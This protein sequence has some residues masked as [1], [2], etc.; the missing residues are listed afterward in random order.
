MVEIL[1]DEADEDSDEDLAVDSVEMLDEIEDDS[2]LEKDH[3]EEEIMIAKQV[4][5]VLLITTLEEMLDEKQNDTINQQVIDLEVSIIG[6]DSD[7]EKDDE[8]DL[9][10]GEALPIDQPLEP[11]DEKD[12]QV[13]TT[14]V[15]ENQDEVSDEEVDNTNKVSK[16]HKHNQI[17]QNYSYNGSFFYSNSTPLKIDILL[18]Q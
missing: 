3:S 5:L 6:L 14:T 12:P 9:E 2:L 4:N 10:V 7:D 16:E 13:D 1:E 15:V 8:K 17:I 18:T 11:I